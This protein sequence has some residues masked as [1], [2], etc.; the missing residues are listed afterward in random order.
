MNKTRLFKGL[1]AVSSC[2]LALSVS[3]TMLC[4][5]WAGHINVALNIRPPVEQ[6]NADTAYYKTAYSEDGTLSD[7][8]LKKMLEASD[9]H[10][11]QTMEEGAVLLKNEDSALPLKSD[12][13]RVTLFG[14]SSA[15]PD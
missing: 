3:M 8:S 5:D 11:V 6:G 14:R 2:A 13:R 4:N 9:K 1:T 12:E 15:D 10:D 7:E